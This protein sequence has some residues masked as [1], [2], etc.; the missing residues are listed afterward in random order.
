MITFCRKCLTPNSRPRVHFDDGVCN[1]CLNAEAKKSIDWEERESE[2]LD[3]IEPY[4]SSNEKYDC[5]VPW[6]GGKDSSAIAHKLKFK[7]GMNPLLVTFS[8]LIPNEI[9]Q[10]NREA[11]IDLGFDHILVRPNQAISRHLT[12]RFF[13]ERGNPK[14]HWDAGINAIPM[15]VALEKN[16]H[17]VFY[18][19]HGESEYGG[20]VLTEESKKIR[21]I[22]EVI[23]HQIG[24]DPLN[25]IDDQVSEKDLNPY[26][27]PEP[28]KLEALGVKALYFAYFHKWSMYENYEYIK[29]KIEFAL[30]AEG[31]TNG[32][33]TNFDSLDDKVD[34]IYYYL[35]FIKFGFGRAVRDA[36]RMIQN[37]HLTREDGLKHALEFDG[38]FPNDHLP[39]FLEYLGLSRDE[40]THIVDMHRNSEVWSNDDNSWKLTHPLPLK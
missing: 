9:G 27:Y 2:F 39:A 14:V 13:I 11:L 7:Y 23:E 10:R 21:D 32:T 16:I 20:R 22:T 12:K 4:R 31:R 17:L 38:E 25:W 3:L 35:Q 28:S 18:A 5:V 29:S 37:D 8:P 26:R 30:A 24:D 34:D 40:F 19:E 15:Q 1:A 36:S 6:S 33:F